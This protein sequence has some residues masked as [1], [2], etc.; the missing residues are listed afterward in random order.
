M[1]W[2][3]CQYCL[4]RSPVASQPP[5]KPRLGGRARLRSRWVK[6]P[7]SSATSTTRLSSAQKI[8]CLDGI[9][10]PAGPASIAAAAIIALAL[11]TVSQA[12]ARRTAATA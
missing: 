10:A 12:A 8:A 2:L 11:I 1:P 3:H 7:S 4:F 5:R 6:S 9:S